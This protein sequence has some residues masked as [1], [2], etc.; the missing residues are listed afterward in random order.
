MVLV[1]L[2]PDLN[3]F[4][5]GGNSLKDQFMR[6]PIGLSTRVTLFLQKF[7]LEMVSKFTDPQTTHIDFGLFLS[8]EILIK[9]DQNMIHAFEIHCQRVRIDSNGDNPLSAI[10]KNWPYE[11]DEL[12]LRTLVQLLLNTGAEIRMRDRQGDTAL[13]IAARRGFRPGIQYVTQFK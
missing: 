2:E 13:V 3:T 12:S 7:Y 8:P 5:S 1:L 11:A 4:D 6:S 9:W 10:L